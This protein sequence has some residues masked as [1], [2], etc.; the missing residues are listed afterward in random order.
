MAFLEQPFLILI[1]YIIRKKRGE[2]FGWEMCSPPIIVTNLGPIIYYKQA[3][4]IYNRTLMIYNG[5][6]DYV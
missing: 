1:I 5:A 4:N 3:L 2:I 6:P